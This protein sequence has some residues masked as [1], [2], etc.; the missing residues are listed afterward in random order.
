MYKRQKQGLLIQTAH[1]GV[2]HAGD[3]AGGQEP[4]GPEQS[5][6]IGHVSG[7]HDD[8]LSLIHIFTGQHKEG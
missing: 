4:D 8:G 1:R 2:G 7:H 3:D 5:R 6:H